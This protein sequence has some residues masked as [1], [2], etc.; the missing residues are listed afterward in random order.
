MYKEDKMHWKYNNKTE[1][2]EVYQEGKLIVDIPRE[3]MEEIRA[4]HKKEIEEKQESVNQL[5][6]LLIDKQL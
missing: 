6:E 5:L 3:V 2:T 4:S 1:K